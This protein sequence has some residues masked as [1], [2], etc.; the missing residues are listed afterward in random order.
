MY[1]HDPLQTSPSQQPCCAEKESP[2]DD[3]VFAAVPLEAHGD[4][5]LLLGAFADGQVVRQTEGPVALRAR[6]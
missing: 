3:L 6:R 5:I 1:V 2:Y 4:Y